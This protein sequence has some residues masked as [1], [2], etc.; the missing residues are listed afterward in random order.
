L[1][2]QSSVREKHGEDFLFI[3]TGVKTMIGRLVFLL[4]ALTAGQSAQ[5]WATDGPA[6]DVPELLV[7]SNYIGAWDVA[8]T[9]KDSPFTKGESTANW[10]LDGRFVQQTGVLS[11]ADGANVLKITTLMTY[12][13]ER[14]TYRMWSFLSNGSTSEGSGTWDEKNRTMTSTSNQ[15]ST[16]TTTTAKFTENG[17]EEWMFVTTNQNKE[18]IGRFGGTNKHRKQK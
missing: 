15:G 2:S 5:V 12:D 10:I 7:L 1:K 13:P 11:S 14:K 16:T 17:S 18:V 6:K 3:S 8:I 9:A 4:I